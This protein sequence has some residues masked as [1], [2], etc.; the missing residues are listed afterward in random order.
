MKLVTHRGV[1]AAY[2]TSL[3]LVCGSYAGAETRLPGCSAYID[4]GTGAIFLQILLG[5][6]VGAGV[7]AKI[8]WHRIAS[9]FASLFKR[10][11]KTPPTS[12]DESQSRENSDEV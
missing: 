2:V 6:I 5:V 8:F 12:S 11:G 4:P 9:F 1:I 7:A 3:L 10:K